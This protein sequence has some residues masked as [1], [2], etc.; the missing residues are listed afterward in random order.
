MPTVTLKYIAKSVTDAHT[1][2]YSSVRKGN[3]LLKCIIADLKRIILSEEKIHSQNLPITQF[4][5]HNIQAIT[6]L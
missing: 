2:E 3:K 1:I 6:K 4:H 5:L